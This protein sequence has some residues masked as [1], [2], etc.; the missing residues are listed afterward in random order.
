MQQEPVQHTK[1][2]SAYLPTLL[3]Q[4]IITHTK[5]NEIQQNLAENIEAVLLFADVSGF[6]SLTE[7]LAQKGMQGTEELTLILNTYFHAI[8]KIIEASGGEVVKFIGDALLVWFPINENQAKKRATNLAWQATQKIQQLFKEKYTKLP[9]SIGNVKMGMKISIG[10]GN[11]NLFEV[12]GKLHRCE[13]VIAG[14][15]VKQL[16]ET[17]KK[18]KNHLDFSIEMSEAA[19]LFLLSLIHI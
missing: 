15:A 10:A 18:H 19:R 16:I 6:T 12:G 14:E 17:S 2:L 9:T 7:Q 5:Q 4:K 8:I 13:C 3:L 1:T 11:I